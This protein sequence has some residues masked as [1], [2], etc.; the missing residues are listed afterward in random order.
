VFVGKKNDT[1]EDDQRGNQQD[2]DSA[3]Q[4]TLCFCSGLSCVGFASG[5]SLRM[6]GRSGGEEHNEQC[7]ASSVQ[8]L[9]PW[10][11]CHLG[12]ERFMNW[13]NNGTVK[14]VSP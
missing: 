1:R 14:A 10:P 4:P 8:A 12:I 2:G 9:A 6:H 13:S 7:E 5:A 3:S 11:G